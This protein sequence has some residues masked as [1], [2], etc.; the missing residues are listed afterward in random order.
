LEV[1]GQSTGQTFKHCPLPANGPKLNN[2][3]THADGTSF[4]VRCG[5]NYRRNRAKK[6]SGPALYEVVSCDLFSAPQKVDH[7]S[8]FLNLPKANTPSG[9]PTFGAAGVPELLVIHVQ[10]P[11][12]APGN[13]LWGAPLVDGEGVSLVV[14]CELSAAGRE[15]CANGTAQARLLRRF[16]SSV[17]DDASITDRMKIVPV[18]INTDEVNLGRLLTGYNGKP[19]LSRPQHRFFRGANYF[20]IVIDVHS[21]TYAARKGAWGFLEKIGDM[22]L[23]LGF[24]VEAEDDDE[25]PEQMLACVRVSRM[26]LTDPNIK[27]FPFSTTSEV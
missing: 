17:P 25:M 23:D 9:A 24:V 11:C 2:C 15:A 26:K 7:I 10:F 19:F 14:V 12:Y 21:F 13:P 20:E 8:R 22:L 5:P 6:N 4:Q 3:W 1:R 27:P 16:T 18:L